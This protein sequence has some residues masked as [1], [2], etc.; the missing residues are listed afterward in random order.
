MIYIQFLLFFYSLLT[1]N[2]CISN[3]FAIVVEVIVKVIVEVIV[4][5]S[6]AVF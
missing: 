5:I 6:E 4:E 3:C 1:S 2:I